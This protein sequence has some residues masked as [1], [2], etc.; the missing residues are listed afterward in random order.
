MLW[1]VAMLFKLHKYT[2]LPTAREA[3]STCSPGCA[4]IRVNIDLIQEIGPKVGGEWVGPLSRDY[5][6]GTCVK[7]RV[8][9]ILS[10]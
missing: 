9:R 10:P 5:S 4:L 2:H 6:T 1:L 3:H 8:T 7:K